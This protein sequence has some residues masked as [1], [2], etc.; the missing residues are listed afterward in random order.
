MKK[1]RDYAEG[2]LLKY[3]PTYIPEVGPSPFGDN[4][5]SHGVCLEHFALTERRRANIDD[6]VTGVE[7][8]EDRIEYIIVYDF[9]ASE[10]LTLE[11]TKWEIIEIN[12]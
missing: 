7:W 1:G 4:P 9:S 5:W 10:K 8:V 2:A 12:E 3:R 6:D 11:T